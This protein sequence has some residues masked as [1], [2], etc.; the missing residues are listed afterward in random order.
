MNVD[1]LH[2]LAATRIAHADLT[3]IDRQLSAG[4]PADDHFVVLVKQALISVANLVDLELTIRS[5]YQRHPDV[6]AEFKRWRRQFEFAKYVRNI[7]VGHTNPALVAKAVEWKPE[8][9]T[10]LVIDNAAASL[11]INLALLETAINTYV[12][13]TEKHLVFGGDTDLAYP[14]DWTRFLIFLTEIV[15][16]GLGFLSTLIVALRAEAPPPPTPEEHLELAMKAGA[17]TFTRITKGGTA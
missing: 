12:D 3:E 14:P 6:S 1:A 13:D 15:R 5:F 2:V 9:R 10:L 17:T 7:L 16:G 8:L 4:A 11:P